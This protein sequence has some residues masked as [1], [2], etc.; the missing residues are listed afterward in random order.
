MSDLTQPRISNDGSKTTGE[1]QHPNG[2][3]NATD[4]RQDYGSASGWHSVDNGSGPVT[5]ENWEHPS[6]HFPD[7]DGWKQT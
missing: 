3:Y 5:D 6:G 2:G 4:R 7:G 1:P